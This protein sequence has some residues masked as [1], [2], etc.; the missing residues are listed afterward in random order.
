MKATH[1]HEWEAA[2]G[3]PEALHGF[4][5]AQISDV[6]VGPTIRHGYLRRIVA[7]VARIASGAFSACMRSTMRPSTRS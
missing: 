4:S 1:E 7:R 3:L 5:V 2:P 6:H